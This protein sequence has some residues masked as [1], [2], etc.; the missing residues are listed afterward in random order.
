MKDREYKINTKVTFRKVS[1]RLL[2]KGYKETYYGD[3]INGDG[4]A[5]Y[6]K[7]KNVI[8]LTYKWIPNPQGRGYVSGR[9]VELEDVS[10]C[11]C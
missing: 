7:G 2:S 6:K 10:E 5:Y 1:A 3:K 9:M 11:Y 4:Y 8:K